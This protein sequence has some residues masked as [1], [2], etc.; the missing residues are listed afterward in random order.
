MPLHQE[1]E[2]MLFDEQAKYLESN[3]SKITEPEDKSEKATILVVE[4]NEDLLHFLTTEL[5]SFYVIF[6]A[7]NGEAALK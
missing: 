3:K 2:F 5:L 7:N 1:E 4:D 6:N